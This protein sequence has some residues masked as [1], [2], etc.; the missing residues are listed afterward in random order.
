MFSNALCRISYGAL[1]LAVA[2]L[3]TCSQAWAALVLDASIDTLPLNGIVDYLE[4]PQSQLSLGDVQR[5]DAPFRAS[6]ERGNI[7]FGYVPGTLWL[8][9]A[10]RSNT[11]S[12][13][14]WR[15]ELDYA[16]LDQVQL[17]DVGAHDLRQAQ[18]GDQ[19]PYPQ[20][21]IAHRAP[22]FEFSLAPGEQ[23]TLYLH[24]QTSGSMTLSGQL[25]SLRAFEQHSQRG[26]LG[27]ALYLGIV[28]A[29]GFYNLLLFCALRERPFI[30][31]VLFLAS[32]A[33]GIVSLNG[34][35]AQY[36]WT[37]GAPW[38]NRIL[39]VSL[40]LTAIFAISFTRSFLE[41]RKWLPSWDRLLYT[42]C[43][44]A[45]ITFFAALLLPVKLSLQIMSAVGV[46]VTF[47]LL[48]TAF[49][50]VVYRVP[51]ARLFA[52]AWMLFLSGAGVMSLRNFAALPSNFFTLYAMQIGSALEMILL[53][54]ALAVRFN[55]LKQQREALLEE[56]ERTL[57]RRVTERTAELEQANQQLSQLALTDALTGLANRPALQQHLALAIGRTQRR[58]E[59][60]AV[61]LLDLDGF[62]PIN[63]QYGHE[64]GDKV[65][66]E[67]GKRMQ[68]AL[69]EIDFAARLG[70]DEF[71]VVCENI[72]SLE[73]AQ[74]LGIR[75]LE[76]LQ[77]PMAFAECQV[78]V[79][80]SVGIA[81][82][83]SQDSA[84]SLLRRADSAMYRAKALGRNRVHM[85]T[86]DID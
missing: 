61:M 70:G 20:R 64:V 85:A 81:L 19:I 71:V 36:A 56:N 45:V 24:V 47:M 39:P 40:I 55:T 50:G 54:L 23:R 51:G 12:L 83:N 41:T 82:Y 30:Y 10:V 11:D 34:L 77:A 21:S 22:V 75:M 76:A 43:I 84:N 37:S 9:L 58:T 79:N 1:S 78:N 27:H 26:Y 28:F 49:V 44:L 42:L 52:L 72:Q 38:T 6:S 5:I 3:L 53:S 69:R 14:H 48:V 46:S 73:L 80:A 7:S 68:S 59:Q 13:Q 67:V 60:L 32:V 66:I 29:L 62:K 65:L 4:D 86:A 8:R 2:L 33:L 15:I 35:G 31:Y 74:S 57:E 25:M 18:S 17:Y 16:S 63:D